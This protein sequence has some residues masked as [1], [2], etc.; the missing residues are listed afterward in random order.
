MESVIWAFKTLYD[1]G[2]A[3]EGYRV[4]P[5]CWRDETPLSNHELRMDD[6]RLQEMRQ[7]PSVTVTFP[8]VGA[9][10]EALGL[11]AVRAHRVDDHA[12]DTADE[13]GTRGGPRHP[14]RRRARGPHAGADV[15]RDD[16]EAEAESHRT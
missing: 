4:L 1:R 7:D 9:K 10:A 11:T 8:L 6:G 16:T 5:Y 12:V 14:L 2:L 3:Y 13:P 15:H